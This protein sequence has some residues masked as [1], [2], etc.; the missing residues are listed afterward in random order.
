M[1]QRYTIGNYVKIS[2]LDE[3]GNATTLLAEAEMPLKV[4]VGKELQVRPCE[5]YAEWRNLGV[6][7]EVRNYKKRSHIEVRTDKGW[8]AIEVNARLE[9]VMTDFMN[10]CES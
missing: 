8:Y 3:Q 9:I 7:S 2:Q 5:R 6:V 1:K 4:V 10:F